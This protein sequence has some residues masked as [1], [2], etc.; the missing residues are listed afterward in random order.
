MRSRR[1]PDVWASGVERAPEGHLPGCGELQRPLCEA[2][3]LPGPSPLRPHLA[4]PASARS[5]GRC[6]RPS[7]RPR[8]GAGG[9]AGISGPLP[10]GSPSPRPGQRRPLGPRVT[11]ELRPRGV[12]TRDS[13]SLGGGCT[14]AAGRGAGALL[15]CI[16]VG[17]G[18]GRGLR[19]G[20]G[21]GLPASSLGR[22]H[23]PAAS[24]RAGNPTQLPGAAHPARP[25]TGRERNEGR[26]KGRGGG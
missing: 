24:A 16:P 20:G 1:G 4:K 17:R 18:A 11:K 2:L 26:G 25:G 15:G 22:G 10:Q 21:G 23:G 7:S 14:A 13:A 8:L 3:P 6:A 5:P 19:A 9:G 12:W